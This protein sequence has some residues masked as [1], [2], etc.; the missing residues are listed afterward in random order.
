MQDSKLNDWIQVLASVGVL[1][2]ILLVFLEIRQTNEI[3]KAEAIAN[4][5]V[6]WESISQIELETD[7]NDL[8]V[9]S[10]NQPDALTNS[11]IMDLSSWFVNVVSI[12]Q[13]R[14]GMYQAGLANDPRPI[15][16]DAANYYFRGRFA[17]AWFEENKGWIRG[18]PMVYE[19]LS[20]EIES[21]PVQM[22]FEYIDRIKSRL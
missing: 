14:E 10:I 21:T 3:A 13:R 6:M 1:G 20:H 19:I 18:S 22:K 8:F 12:H 7:I 17:R 9:K 16:K 2:G 4:E 11:E 15:I 5:Y